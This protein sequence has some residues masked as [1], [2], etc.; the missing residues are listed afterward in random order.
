[1][2]MK[3]AIII[4][5]IAAAL[6]LLLGLFAL[7]TGEDAPLPT[8]GTT[9]PPTTAPTTAPTET[10]APPTEAPTTEPTTVPTEPEPVFAPQHTASSDPANW[11]TTWDIMAQD[12]IVES[13]TRAEPIFFE[14]DA[15]FALPGVATFRGSNYRTDASYGTAGI[16]EAK[17]TP[18][19]KMNVG[20][21]TEI[22]WIGCGWTGQPLVVQW[23]EETKALMNLYED[24]KA[25]EGLVEVIYAKMDG[26][27][28]FF[29]I[30][31]GTPTRDPVYVGMVF[32]GSGALDPRGYPLLY[33][34][35]GLKEGDRFQNIYIVSL[36]DGSI[37]YR[38]SGFDSFAHR[39]WF[40]F[41]SSPLVDADTD[42]L[43]WPGESGVL[44]T[45]KLNT[46][47]DTVGGTISVA[48]DTVVKCR[49]EN[50]Y[51]RSDRYLG[52]EGSAVVVDH[53]LFAGD[54]A[55]MLHCIDL[56]TMELIWAQDILDD[57]NSTPVFDWGADGRGYLYIAPSL[58][59]AGNGSYSMLPICKL[60]AQT[61]EI[62]WTYETP[63]YT[64]DGVSGG[65]LSS[66]MLGRPGT[67]LEDLIVYSVGRSPSA[68]T[69][70]MVALN[71]HTGEVVWEMQTKNYMWSSPLGIYDENGKGYIFQGDAS[72]NCYLLDGATGQV[73]DMV[74]LKQTIEASPVA[75]GDRIVMGTRS[76]IVLFAV[77]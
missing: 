9:A 4:T 25:K 29:D 34:G 33:L 70:T 16:T 37:L 15:Y 64:E 36:L 51:S 20:W 58:D 76:A 55:G 23:D 63:C 52:C 28:H 75:F 32:K 41:D 59:Y 56:N 65:T 3:R 5:V 19:W 13:Y 66:P 77:N 30:E 46:H 73:L 48:P 68:W 38:Q 61:G 72:G 45:M 67:D 14:D 1:M 74:A 11:H 22:E 26:R 44:Y 50:D 69:G 24:K 43:I 21:L 17:L 7:R 54:N 31:D 62:L 49:Y 39:G 60:D 35:A 6:L 12:Q 10:T 42:T 27:V 57:L 8:Q 40:A 18:I 47:Y 71:K 53:Y 2:L